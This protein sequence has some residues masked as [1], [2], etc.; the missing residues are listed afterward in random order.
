MLHQVAEYMLDQLVLRTRDNREWVARFFLRPA[1]FRSALALYAHPTLARVLPR[2]TAVPAAD[3]STAAATDAAGAP[4][5][6]MLLLEKAVPLSAWA[7]LSRPS[8][9]SAVPVRPTLLFPR[10]SVSVPRYD[11]AS[12]LPTQGY[13]HFLVA[14]VT[15]F[16]RCSPGAAH[17]ACAL[18]RY[19]LRGD[20]DTQ[21]AGARSRGEMPGRA[22]R[23][24]V[25]LP[26]GLSRFDRVA[27][28]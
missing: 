18:A 3:G 21:R 16:G 7:R 9:A 28:V 20:Q 19:G 4:L 5:P 26:V 23:R 10:F 22:T 6:P 8:F 14:R 25:C 1:A 17:A 12:N 11:Q 15:R 2:I 24:R 27:A 13:R